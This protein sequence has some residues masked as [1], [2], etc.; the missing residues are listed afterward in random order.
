MKRSSRPILPTKEFPVP[1]EI[2]AAAAIRAGQPI[3]QMRKV[4]RLE[5]DD[6]Q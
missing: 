4:L 3:E 6:A 2:V 1:G 5:G